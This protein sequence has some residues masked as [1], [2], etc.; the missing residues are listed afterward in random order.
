LGIGRGICQYPA[1]PPK[2][3]TAQSGEEQQNKDEASEGSHAAAAKRVTEISED[4]S[5]IHVLFP[6][7]HCF[8]IRGQFPDLLPILKVA[9][10]KKLAS[11]R[12]FFCNNL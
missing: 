9:G 7:V 3:E 6:P 2:E 11:G 12:E 4:L 1:Y 8:F 5:E 10:T